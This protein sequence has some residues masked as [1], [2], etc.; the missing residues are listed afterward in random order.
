MRGLLLLRAS[1]I[2]LYSIQYPPR[3]YWHRPSKVLTP[4]T[5]SLFRNKQDSFILIFIEI[6]CLVASNRL[7]RFEKT[8]EMLI[9]FNGLSN[10]RLQQM[11]ERF[12][13][14]TRTLV[15]MKK[16]LDSVFRRIRWVTTPCVKRTH[17]HTH[18]VSSSIC[19]NRTLK[20][21]IAKQYPEAFSSQLQTQLLAVVSPDNKQRD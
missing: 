7:D 3:C 6:C 2:V 12:L 1:L 4:T 18:M 10:V 21:K 14:H 11:N 8:N 19:F 13:Q 15:E 17:T 16:D 20:G 5:A 9:N